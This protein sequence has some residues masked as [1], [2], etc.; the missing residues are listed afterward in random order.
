MKPMIL[1]LHQVALLVAANVHKS[2]DEVVKG[3]LVMLSHDS[4]ATDMGLRF[5]LAD[6]KSYQGLLREERGEVTLTTFGRESFAHTIKNF[7]HVRE[8]VS[9]AV[10]PGGLPR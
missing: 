2:K 8:Q 3:A 9:L 6:M 7:D 10:W 1:S 5:L 4:T